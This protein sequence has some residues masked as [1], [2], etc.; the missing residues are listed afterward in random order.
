[1]TLEV[2]GYTVPHLKG[3]RYGKDETRELGYGHT[4]RIRQD[5]MKSDNL[6]HKQDFK[7]FL[8]QTTVSKVKFILEHLT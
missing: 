2:Q 1:M 6:L 7:D 8:L 5:V 4:S 3:L